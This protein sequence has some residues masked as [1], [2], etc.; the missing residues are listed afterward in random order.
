MRFI[1]FLKY[2]IS[3]LL[4]GL[5]RFLGGKLAIKLAY[6]TEKGAPKRKS[7]STQVQ[8]RET[9]FPFSNCHRFPL[10]IFCKHFFQ[11]VYHIFSMKNNK[12]QWNKLNCQTKT[13]Y[14]SISDERLKVNIDCFSLMAAVENAV[15]RLNIWYFEA[16]NDTFN[17]V[18]GHHSA[19][20]GY[21]GTEMTWANE[22]NLGMQ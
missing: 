7:N 5:I 8:N 19:L 13:T 14:T 6:F 4:S 2:V 10:F 3:F 11:S 9:T 22:M 18:L 15:Q 16:M 1:I 20:Q 21:T 17:G 12:C